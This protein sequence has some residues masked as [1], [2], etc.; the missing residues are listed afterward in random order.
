MQLYW[1]Q[2]KKVL[3]RRSKPTLAITVE[4]GNEEH[5][6]IWNIYSIPIVNTVSSGLLRNVS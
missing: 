5:V 1:R 6:Q 4:E 3:E 2:E